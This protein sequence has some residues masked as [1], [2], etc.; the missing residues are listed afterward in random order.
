MGPLF[1]VAYG[2]NGPQTNV[3]VSTVTNGGWSE[4]FKQEYGAR[5]TSSEVTDIMNTHCTADNIMLACRTTDSTTIQLLAWATRDCVFYDS[6]SSRSSTK[7][8]EGTEWYFSK[9]Y[10]WGFAPASRT[11]RRYSCDTESSDS[12]K[13]LCW[14]TAASV[15]GWRCGSNKWLNYNNGYEK[16]IY[17]NLGEA[18][19]YI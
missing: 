16:L 8:C 19:I 13:R 5:L 14:H 15:G 3:A 10:S 11:V 18:Y 4:C 9:T 6:G 17:Q 1:S 2:P 7:N 12:S